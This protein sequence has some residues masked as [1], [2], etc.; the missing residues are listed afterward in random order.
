MENYSRRDPLPLHALADLT[1]VCQ[2]TEKRR[3]PE[4][5]GEWLVSHREQ[6]E[7][8]KPRRCD[9]PSDP[10]YTFPPTSQ[11]RTCMPSVTPAPFNSTCP[12]APSST[13]LGEFQFIIH[14]PA[15]FP[16][17]PLSVQGPGRK[18]LF[19]PLPWF[20]VAPAV[21]DAAGPC[22]PLRQR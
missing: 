5:E 12:A 15:P 14:L 20:G 17:R 6:N 8:E 11:A 21:C 22:Q 2:S 13:A 7:K 4:I 3:L 16:L 9:Y 1:A 19:A 10:L 18:V